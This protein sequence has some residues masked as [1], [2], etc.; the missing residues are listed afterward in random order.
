MLYKGDMSVRPP[1][2]RASADGRDVPLFDAVLFIEPRSCSPWKRETSPSSGANRPTNRAL[3]RIVWSY[4]D[5]EHIGLK[6]IRDEKVLDEFCY[7]DSDEARGRRF[8]SQKILATQSLLQ[9]RQALAN[10][11]SSR[12]QLQEL[13]QEKHQRANLK[14]YSTAEYYGSPAHRGKSGVTSS[15]KSTNANVSNARHMSM[16]GQSEFVSLYWTVE[17]MDWHCDA[18]LPM[19]ALIPLRKMVIKAM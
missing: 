7:P 19:Q 1:S 17:Y 9:S 5:V 8:H 4:P 14:G 13:Q 6:E 2:F 15:D 10:S 11:T 18:S 16:C 3:S 12:R